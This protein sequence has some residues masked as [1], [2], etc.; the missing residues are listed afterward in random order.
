LGKPK[1][2]RAARLPFFSSAAPCYSSAAPISFHDL[3]QGSAMSRISWLNKKVLAAAVVMLLL[4]VGGV[5]FMERTALLSWYYVHN[6]ARADE[7]NQ[8]V[9][10]ERVAGLGENV[11]PSLLDCLADPDPRVCGNAHAALGR[12]S[13]QWGNGDARSVALAMRCG[14][15]FNRF[16]PS[17]QQHILELATEWFRAPGGDTPP[18]PGLL[19]ACVRFL[20]E[21]SASTDT[22]TQE[23]AL[24]L[25]AVLL[26]Q[27]QGMEALSAGRDVV[28]NCLTSNSANTRMR[29]V[30]LALY[31]GMDVLEQV[32]PLLND[33][34][35]EVRRRAMTAMENA[36]Y[37]VD[38]ALLPSLHD[39][40]PEVRRLC[41]KTLLSRNL[42]PQQ[43]RLSFLLTAHDP[44]V[45]IETLDYLPRVKE[46]D[47]SLLLIRLSHDPSPAIRAAAARAMSR[48]LRTDPDLAKRLDEMARTDPSATVCLLAKYYLENPL[49]E[50]VFRNDPPAQRGAL[51]R[52]A[53]PRRAW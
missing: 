46:V 38:D 42:S 16:S 44:A 49:D 25:C 34:E 32:V 45:R 19:A 26:A 11:V 43:I 6:L 37:V 33:P 7:S 31:P 23:H 13:Q 30:E 39:S 28:R 2:P 17:G 12:L 22:A 29:A 52:D 10:A 18:A 9:W 47:L 53:L 14:R 50:V 35:V 5:A 15:D 36:K 48:L 27:P 4:L 41:Q 3:E 21:T 8:V 1:A 24:E 40:D 20:T 51:A